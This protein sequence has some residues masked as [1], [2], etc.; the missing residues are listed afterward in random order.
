[1]TTA[2]IFLNA[3]D[4]PTPPETGAN[5]KMHSAVVRRLGGRILGGDF[6]PGDSLPGE[7]ELALT[8]AVSRTTIR[9]A[10]KVLSAKGLIESRPRIGIRVRPQEDWRVL[11]PDLLSWHPDIKRD[12]RFLE[13]LVES[14]RIIEPAAAELAAER[15]TA[16][17]LALIE[18]AYDAMKKNAR[19]NIT[20]CNEAD[21][22][23]H[24]AVI[25]ASHNVILKAL[26]STIEAA[27]RAAF[28]VTSEHMDNDVIEAHHHIMERI[29]FR[30]TEGARKAMLHLLDIAAEDL[31]A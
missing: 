18:R 29:R 27:L 12:A 16:Q 21:V 24:H 23:F 7:S 26:T 6:K 8:L 28:F 15:A 17:D 4:G 20:A 19:I 22:Q 3:Y 1:M 25:G 31:Y 9:E 10:I 11:D 5:G 13:S 30:D 2:T 14:R